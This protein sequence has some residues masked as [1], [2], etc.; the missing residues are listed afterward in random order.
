MYVYIT[1]YVHF[2]ASRPSAA[3]HTRVS[4][5]P[6]EDSGRKRKRRTTERNTRKNVIRDDTKHCALARDN[7][8]ALVHG[9]TRESL[10]ERLV[11]KLRGRT[12]SHPRRSCP[13]V[14]CYRAR[15]RTTH[16]YVVHPFCIPSFTHS[17]I[18]SAPPA[19]AF[20]FYP[21]ILPSLCLSFS[22]ELSFFF[23]ISFSI[24]YQSALIIL[25]HC[26]RSLCLL[27]F[28]LY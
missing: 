4:T 18:T 8:L 28:L 25:Y 24:T 11:T 9:R 5:R 21:I 12:L 16:H 1:Q 3:E 19:P 10:L 17:L 20:F 22:L 14:P 23:F 2:F 7:Q 13:S 27:P 6:D 15:A 26:V